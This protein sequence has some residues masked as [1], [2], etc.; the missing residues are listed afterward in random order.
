MSKYLVLILA[1]S[2]VVVLNTGLARAQSDS[3]ADDPG[4]LPSNPLYFLKEWGRGIKKLF[5][6]SD[7]KE[8]EL[9]LNELN[10]RAAEL[11]KLEEISP[12][13]FKAITRASEKYQN[14]IER[15]KNRLSD[16][17]ETAQNSRVGDLLNG[18]IDNSLKHQ[19]L[20]DELG[21]KLEEKN[22]DLKDKIDNSQEKITELV[23]EVS[24]KFET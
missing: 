11:K 5:T 3:S 19:Q 22:S 2:L 6:F 8:A 9:E 18:L 15:L 1:F 14:N 20:F 16:I 12:Q 24:N 21:T 17:K 7:I 13:N 4:I 23:A 10:D